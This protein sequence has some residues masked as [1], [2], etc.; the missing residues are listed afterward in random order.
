MTTQNS[1]IRDKSVVLITLVHG[2]W[3]HGC[4]RSSPGK[5]PSWFDED[6][7]FARSLTKLLGRRGVEVVFL[8][9]CVWSGGNSLQARRSC[10]KTIIESQRAAVKMDPSATRIVIAHSHGGTSAV[11]AMSKLPSRLMPHSLITMATPFIVTEKRVLRKG[12][13]LAMRCASGVGNIMTLMGA[14]FLV[15]FILRLLTPDAVVEANMDFIRKHET[16]FNFIFVALV[17]L[18]GKTMLKIGRKLRLTRRHLVRLAEGMGPAEVG[19]CKVLV[20]RAPSD[21]ASLALGVGDAAEWAHSI[22]RAAFAIPARVAR[23]LRGSR[24]IVGTFL[25]VF[26]ISMAAGVLTAAYL[27]F[28]SSLIEDGHPMN[29]VATIFM[30]GTATMAAPFVI[31]IAAL[32]L[33]GLVASASM[34]LS[35][36]LSFGHGIEYPLLGW[37]FRTTA[38]SSPLGIRV[39]TWSLSIRFRN[40]LRHGIYRHAATRRAIAN[41]IDEIV[42]SGKRP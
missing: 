15:V 14:A 5:S 7:A 28:V 31:G 36:L 32:L 11:R 17:A 33:T 3:A 19:S 6:E 23:S 26:W 10:A 22:A 30:V 41:W 29:A 20:L 40:G 4:F 35:S 25:A 37:S 12:E 16:I 9:P 27:L 1:S 42:Q 18:V 8:P 34:L 13:Q 24:I 38:E 2:T 21:E 39:T